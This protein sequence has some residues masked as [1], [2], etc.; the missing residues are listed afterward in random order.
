MIRRQPNASANGCS[1]TWSESVALDHRLRM[2]CV[3]ISRREELAD[4]LKAPPRALRAHPCLTYWGPHARDRTVS[5]DAGAVLGCGRPG[6]DVARY[7]PVRNGAAKAAVP[8]PR[9]LLPC[10]FRAARR[11][12][13][14][15]FTHVELEFSAF[16]EGI[17]T[18]LSLH[19]LQGVPVWSAF[20]PTTSSAYGCQRD[21]A[22]LRRRRSR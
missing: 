1:G 2:P 10:R 8:S 19:L 14:F 5:G 4:I 11:A 18:A 7:L 13:Q 3:G 15:S 20:S 6:Y 22:P 16:G 12:V 9:K 17:E 21:C